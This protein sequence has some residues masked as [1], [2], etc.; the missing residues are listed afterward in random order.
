MTEVAFTPP[1]GPTFTTTYSYDA[2][3]NIIAMTYPSGRQ[4]TFNRDGVRRIEGIDADINASSSTLVSNIQYQADN[5]VTAR[6]FAND[7]TFGIAG[8]ARRQ[9]SRS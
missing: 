7:A 5:Q 4:V 8:G 6:T 1:G 9:R 2:G 3:D